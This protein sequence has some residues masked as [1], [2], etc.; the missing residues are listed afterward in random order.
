[1]ETGPAAL[2]L[3]SQT[4]AAGKVFLFSATGTARPGEEEESI[5]PFGGGYFVVR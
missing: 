1:M 5:A 2:N 3:V 4:S